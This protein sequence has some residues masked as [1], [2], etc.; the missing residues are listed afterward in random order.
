M[1]KGIN[2]KG[3]ELPGT[4]GKGCVAAAKWYQRENR[5]KVDGDAGSQTFGDLII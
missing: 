4:Y 2:P 3:V 5:L 1:L